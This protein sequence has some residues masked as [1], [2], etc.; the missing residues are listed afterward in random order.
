MTKPA[1]VYTECWGHFSSEMLRCM[2]IQRSVAIKS[3]KFCNNFA[4]G[5]WNSE[6]KKSVI[7]GFYLLH[8][9]RL[10]SF[11]NKQLTANKNRCL[12]RSLLN[13]TVHIICWTSWNNTNTTSKFTYNFKFGSFATPSYR[14]KIMR[15]LNNSVIPLPEPALS[16]PS[17]QAGRAV[18]KVVH[19]C[20][21][22]KEDQNLGEWMNFFLW[23]RGMNSIRLW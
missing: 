16:Y 18:T 12:K 23:F 9:D 7:T 1:A 5:F 6:Q 4:L 8:S 19:R 21:H 15:D 3:M 22:A 13:L 17:R 14:T 11:S 10:V 20:Q 2:E